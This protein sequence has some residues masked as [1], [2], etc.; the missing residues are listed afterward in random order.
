MSVLLILFQNLYLLLVSV[1]LKL[2]ASFSISHCTF[3][4]LSYLQLRQ[5]FENKC[6]SNFMYFAIEFYLLLE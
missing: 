4:T 6:E 1:C 2:N 3:L 5:P